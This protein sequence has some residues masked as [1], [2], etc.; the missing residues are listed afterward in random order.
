MADDPQA[1]CLRLFTLAM[2]LADQCYETFGEADESYTE[3]ALVDDTFD[4]LSGGKI[5]AA[6]P[7]PRHQQRELLGQGGLLEVETVT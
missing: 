1:E 3:S 4:G 5:L 2:M 7:Q 6:V